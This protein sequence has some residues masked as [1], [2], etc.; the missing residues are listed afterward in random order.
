MS[1]KDQELNNLGDLCCPHPPAPSSKLG[2]P[3]TYKSLGHGYTEVY[4]LD[5]NSWLGWQPPK[6]PLWRTAASPIPPPEGLA[7][8]RLKT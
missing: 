6:P 5:P 4:L 3:C 1:F 7:G 2:L 8:E